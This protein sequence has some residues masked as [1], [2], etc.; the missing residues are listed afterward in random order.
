MIRRSGVRGVDGAGI[1][2]SP[3]EAKETLD[4]ADLVGADGGSSPASIALG[5]AKP[6]RSMANIVEI[7][8]TNIVEKPLKHDTSDYHLFSRRIT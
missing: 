5:L 7:A 8:C 6:N 1:R 4:R 2:F 3:D